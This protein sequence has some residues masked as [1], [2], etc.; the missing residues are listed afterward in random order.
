MIES[1]TNKASTSP[2]KS[3]DEYITDTVSIFKNML[4]TL[5]ECHNRNIIHG[6]IKPENILLDINQYPIFI[7]FGQSV[8]LSKLN[9][10]LGYMGTEGYAPPELDKGITGYFTDI[11]SLG[12]TLYISL[13]GKTPHILDD[14]S[15]DWDFNDNESELPFKVVNMIYDMTDPQYEN[16]PSVTMLEDYL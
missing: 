4:P 10:S 7:D 8:D 13:L 1:L 15:I 12:I 16:R 9:N 14:G 2:G 6:D 3:K 11:Y 5:A